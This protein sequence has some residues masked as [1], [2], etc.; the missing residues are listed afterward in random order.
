MD[1]K[2]LLSRKSPSIY[3]TE[4]ACFIVEKYIFQ[5]KGEI[6]KINIFKNVDTQNIN[7]PISRIA[8]FI[9]NRK[10]S[11][12]TKNSVFGDLS[13]SRHDFKKAIF[14]NCCEILTDYRDWE[15][16]RKSVV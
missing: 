4:E 1:I 6:V 12:L 7:H 16:D 8:D 14:L 11:I 10:H 5:E 2:E 9:F 3:T 13:V 15:T